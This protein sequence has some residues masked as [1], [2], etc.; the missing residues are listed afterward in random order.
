MALIPNPC[1][2]TKTHTDCPRRAAG[3]AIGC[4]DWAEYE[5]KR[6]KIRDERKKEAQLQQACIGLR[7]MTH[8]KAFRDKIYAKRRRINNT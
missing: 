2:N 6:D 1:Y 7:P 4:S 5:K 3:C 8:N